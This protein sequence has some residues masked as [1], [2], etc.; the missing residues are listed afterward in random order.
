V[1]ELLVRHP[2]LLGELSY[3]P[4]LTDNGGLAPPW[5]AMCTDLPERFLIGSDTWINPRWLHYEGLMDEA[6]TWLGSLPEPI[7]R[8]I[9]WGN[10]AGLFGLPAPLPLK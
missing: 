2:T 10:G 3:R 8:R 5:R 4:G 6:R 7:A 9:G 1:R